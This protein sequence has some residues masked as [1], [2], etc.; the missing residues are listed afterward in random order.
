MVLVPRRSCGSVYVDFAGPKGAEYAKIDLE[1]IE[2]T[3]GEFY[4]KFLLL[5]GCWLNSSRIS[6]RWFI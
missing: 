6:C 2:E 1:G 3:Y 5:F 4:R